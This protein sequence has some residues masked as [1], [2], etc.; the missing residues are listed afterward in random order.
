[1]K[2]LYGQCDRLALTVKYSKS[3]CAICWSVKGWKST[4]KCFYNHSLSITRPTK[5]GKEKSPANGHCQSEKEIKDHLLA[6]QQFI[7]ESH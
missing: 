4:G 7:T 3:N 2:K 5:R 6:N 1:L